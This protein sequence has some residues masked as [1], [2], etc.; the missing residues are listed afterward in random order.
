MRE[1]QVSRSLCLAIGLFAGLR[2]AS[3]PLV[4]AGTMHWKTM[5]LCTRLRR[6]GAFGRFACDVTV[7]KRPRLTESYC[8]L[9]PFCSYAFERENERGGSERE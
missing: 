4:L 8:R 1:S 2:W 9:T 6:S 3:I 7:M 5:Y